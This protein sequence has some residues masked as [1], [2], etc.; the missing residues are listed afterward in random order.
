MFKLPNDLTD[1]L[2]NRMHVEVQSFILPNDIP[3]EVFFVLYALGVLNLQ[4]YILCS[5]LYVHV[6]DTC[7][8]FCTKTHLMTV[9]CLIPMLHA[10]VSAF[11]KTHKEN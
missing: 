6:C 5:L 4:N 1:P 7:T 11:V 10:L 8:K 9:P 2:N 3:N